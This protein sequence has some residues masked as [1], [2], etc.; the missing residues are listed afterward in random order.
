VRKEEARDDGTY[1]VGSVPERMLSA[2]HP[3]LLNND[4]A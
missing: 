3:F 1:I 4:E 2:L